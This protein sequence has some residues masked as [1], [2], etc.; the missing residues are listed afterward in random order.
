MGAIQFR[1]KSFRS[2]GGVASTL[3]FSVLSVG[4]SDKEAPT[5]AS[6]EKP[7][8]ATSSAA[9]TTEATQ[10]ES[11]QGMTELSAKD[12]L[13]PMVKSGECNLERA[14]NEKFSRDAMEIA[15]ANG[16]VLLE[17]WIVDV[18]SRNVPARIFVRLRSSDKKRTWQTTATTGIK[19]ASLASWLGDPVAYE[20]AG[21]AASAD[22][23]ALPNDSYR[24]YVAYRD[25]SAVLKYCGNGRVIK[26]E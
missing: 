13:E 5:S 20:L 18:A 22:V 15:K 1:L 4:C 14:G 6:L 12:R 19:R 24:I 25:Q 10:L 11:S 3:L 21:Y 9:P 23:S 2:L 26:L 17:G 16:P 7:Q 8:P